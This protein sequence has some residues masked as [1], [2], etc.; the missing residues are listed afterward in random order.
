MSNRLY[1]DVET[2]PAF[3]LDDPFLEK[4]VKKGGKAFEEKLIDPDFCKIIAIGYGG[5]IMS[6]T[7]DT[8][9]EADETQILVEFWDC[10][11]DQLISFNGKG[12]DLPVIIRRSQLLGLSGM[13]PNNIDDYLNVYRSE[14][15]LDLMHYLGFN[16]KWRS[17]EFYLELFGC[18]TEKFGDGSQIHE[19]Y[20]AGDWESI[21][22]HLEADIK[23]MI[24]LTQKAGV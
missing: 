12:F 19:W 3:E 24:E 9:E 8:I 22:K 11:T 18:E 14:H 17:Q 20:K 10:I 21:R 1:F 23:G 7:I 13:I 5:G 6:T 15:H 2:I 4:W 16:K